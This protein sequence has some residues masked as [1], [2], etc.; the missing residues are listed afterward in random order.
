M[1]RRVVVMLVAAILA[2]AVA[3]PV[4][5][6]ER[7][8]KPQVQG[9]TKRAMKKAKTAL[10]TARQA[11][12]RAGVA[13][14]RA[15]GAAHLAAGAESRATQA[16]GAAAGAKAAADSAGATA[17]AAKEA[18]DADRAAVG[19]AAGAAATESADF[20]ALAGGPTVT[21]TVPPSG[22]VEVWA[23]AR[24]D[25]EGAVSLFEGD[26]PVPGQ[27]D[28]CSPEE[29]VGVLFSLPSAVG[30]PVTIATPAAF[31]VAGCGTLGAPGPVLFEAS[32]GVHTYELRYAS[33]GC[34]DPADPVTF[35]NR[36]LIVAPRP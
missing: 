10:R 19:L 23:Q 1:S 14:G 22:L 5:A 35:S 15:R 36:R 27:S 21:V 18:V 9:L 13:A 6:G 11:K 28:L 16:W 20:V 7:A 29:G 33:C 4:T 34:E 30:E 25:G 31:G 12:R 3:V 8:A 32:P 17:A 26:A 2:V 24:I